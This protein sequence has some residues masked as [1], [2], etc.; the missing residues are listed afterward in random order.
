M[1]LSGQNLLHREATYMVTNI[2]IDKTPPVS[3]THI[4][5]YSNNSNPLYANKGDI[6]TASFVINESIHTPQVIF[7][8]DTVLL[9]NN[10]TNLNGNN[11]HW[12]ATYVIHNNDPQGTVSITITATDK[13]G[14][15][16]DIS[17]AS[18]ITIQ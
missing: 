9:D 4:T 18:S 16:T 14:N 11:T 3:F 2:T 6:I 7:K 15:I 5:I 12:E 10:S 17:S 1:K 13:A 8:S